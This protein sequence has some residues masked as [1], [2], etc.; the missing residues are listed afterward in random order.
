MLNKTNGGIN[1]LALEIYRP[2]NDIFKDVKSTDLSMSFIDWAP[3]PPDQ[4]MGIWQDVFLTISGPLTVR[5]PMVETILSGQHSSVVAHLTVMAEV[6]NLNTQ[7]SISGTLIGF[8]ESI[9]SFQ[10]Q[11]TLNP[12]ETKQIFFSNSSFPNLNVKNPD[13]WWP[14]QMGNSSLHTLNFTLQVNSQVSDTLKVQFGIRQMSSA[15]DSNKRRYYQVNG[16]NI[17]IRGAGFF[18]SFFFF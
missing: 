17:L 2:H 13:L 14:W 6:S 15:L 10:Q 11:M 12:S 1:T 8:I 3:Y 7:T 5:Y 4:N 9:G 18:L 16:K